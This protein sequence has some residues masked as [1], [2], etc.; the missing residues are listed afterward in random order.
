VE[1]ANVQKHIADCKDLAEQT[2]APPPTS[3]SKDESKE[4]KEKAA[5]KA[6][7][8][9]DPAAGVAILTDLFIETNDPTYLFN[10]GRCFE[11]NRRYEEAISRFRE[12]LVKAQNLRPQE[13]EDTRKHI[14]DCESWAREKGGEPAKAEARKVG[15]EVP[16]APQKIGATE[17]VPSIVGAAAAPT[18]PARPGAELRVVGLT[19]AG[20][21]VAG[22]A[23]GILLNLKANQLSKDVQ[24]DWDPNVESSRKSYQTAGWI[25]YGAGA[26]CLLG[27]AAV[28][29][30][31]MQARSHSD[32]SVAFVPTVGPNWAGTVLKGAF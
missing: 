14:A 18:S 9:G 24:A 12:Y 11:Q 27:G 6:C 2:K 22:L 26:A 13:K 30:W 8:T 1:K 32:S 3:E 23:T 10:Q 4:G 17:T 5:K 25:A 20:L 15:D 16:G 31:G 19:V 21:G 29:Y 7:L 28:F